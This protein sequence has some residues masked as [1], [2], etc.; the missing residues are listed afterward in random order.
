VLVDFDFSLISRHLFVAHVSHVSKLVG[1]ALKLLATLAEPSIAVGN[2]GLSI[3]EILG[4]VPTFG[5]FLLCFLLPFL[6]HCHFHVFLLLEAQEALADVALGQRFAHELAVA[7]ETG[8]LLPVSLQL[9]LA[10]EVHS[11]VLA[12]LVADALVQLELLDAGKVNFA[13]AAHLRLRMFL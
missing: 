13:L 12:L 4:A 11:T 6:L 8:V 9:L 7:A 10:V 2:Q 3:G 5:D 1:L